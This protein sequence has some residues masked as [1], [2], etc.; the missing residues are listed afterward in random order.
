METEKDREFHKLFEQFVE[1]ATRFE[2][3]DRDELVRILITL[4]KHLR[5]A[6]GVAEF[7]RSE[8]HRRR[9]EGQI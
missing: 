8:T 9:G 1:C 5:I 4:A 3:Y 6:K 2:G 7:Y